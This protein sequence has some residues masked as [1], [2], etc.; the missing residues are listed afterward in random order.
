MLLKKRGDLIIETARE[1]TFFILD[2]SF[3]ILDGVGRLDLKG[4]GLAREGL[5]E[6]LHP[7]GDSVRS[8]CEKIV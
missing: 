4:D 3:D 1:Q 7:D 5:D 2:L 8:S 6:D